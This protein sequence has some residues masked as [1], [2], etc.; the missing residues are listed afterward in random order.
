MAATISSTPS[1]AITYT[2]AD[3]TITETSS[4]GSSLIFPDG[5]GTGQVNIGVTSTGY[6]SSGETVIY[7]FQ[8]F[9]K[10]I[11]NS[12]ILLDFTSE[13]EA[14]PLIT[15]LDNPE[16]GIKALII[17]NSWNTKVLG[18]GIDYLDTWSGIVTPD[19]TGLPNSALPRINIRATGVY[20][21]ISGGFSQ[22][23]NSKLADGGTGNI[24]INPQSTWSFVDPVGKT[25]LYSTGSSVY[26]HTLQI[27]T[28]NFTNISGSGGLS[29][30]TSGDAVYYPI[31]NDVTSGNPWSG[32][33][34]RISYE[35]LA[36]GVTG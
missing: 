14:F 13:S 16:R 17:T 24:P 30:G 35:I 5:T 6:I 26:M 33:L 8:K 18:S 27:V 12:Q 2:L 21:A 11:W 1:L 7:D 9:P 29:S 34:P 19:G 20:S 28:E 10:E 3:G 32:N 4:V 25:P 36:I 31:W 22:L 15:N 23:F